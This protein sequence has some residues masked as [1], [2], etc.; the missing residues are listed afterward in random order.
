MKTY[1]LC[2]VNVSMSFVCLRC[3]MR[4]IIDIYE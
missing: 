2:F 1:M 3:R 4:D